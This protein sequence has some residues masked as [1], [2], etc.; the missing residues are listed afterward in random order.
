MKDLNIESTTE[1][2]T[3]ELNEINGGGFAYDAGFFLRETWVYLKNGGGA[4]GTAAVAV[5]LSVNY[6]PAN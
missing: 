5:D 3:L 2:T 4:S 6:R 1:L